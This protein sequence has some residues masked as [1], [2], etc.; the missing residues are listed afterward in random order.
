MSERDEETAAG[1]PPAGPDLPTGPPPLGGPA[2]APDVPVRPAAS[3]PPD[4]APVPA[5]PRPAPAPSG[6]PPRPSPLP[7]PRPVGPGAPVRPDP[8]GVPPTAAVRQVVRPRRARLVLK[9][10][11]PWSVFLHSV[12]AAVFIGFALVIAIGLLY[13]VMSKLGVLT[14]LNQL[15]ADVTAE[16]GSRAAPAQFFSVGKVMTFAAVVA[17]VDVVLLTALATLGAMLYN[18]GA[19]LT[20]GIEVTVTDRG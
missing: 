16:P 6:V 17:A 18:A 11:D 13:A 7:P 8:R 15:I 3:P 10:V 2:A 19:A 20:G 14:S 1:S 5:P 4:I 9:R 12:V